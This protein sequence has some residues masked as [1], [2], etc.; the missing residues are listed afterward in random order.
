MPTRSVCICASPTSMH[1]MTLTWD[2][3]ALG[4]KL[5]LKSCHEDAQFKVLQGSRREVLYY[6]HL[7]HTEGLIFVFY[8]F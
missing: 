8:L 7:H 2:L 3:T 5:R 1:S 4:K 6:L